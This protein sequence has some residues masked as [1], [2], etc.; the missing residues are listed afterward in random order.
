MTLS[1]TEYGPFCDPE[2]AEDDVGRDR[3]KVQVCQTEVGA[4]VESIDFDA[5]C[6][7][8]GSDEESGVTWLL[9]P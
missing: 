7:T 1:V 2:K 8:L 9:L 3:Y 6:R 5:T 4:L